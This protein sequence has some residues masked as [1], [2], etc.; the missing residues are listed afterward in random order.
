MKRDKS[1]DM[2]LSMEWT[3]YMPLSKHGN[4]VKFS[5]EVTHDL[6]RFRRGGPAEYIAPQ[7][8]PCSLPEMKSFDSNRWITDGEH[9]SLT[10]LNYP[11]EPPYSVR[12]HMTLNQNYVRVEY[13]RDIL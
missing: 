10:L 5:A 4:H 3:G 12:T 6:Q 8:A 11:S 1:G 13:H 2:F 7:L 9:T